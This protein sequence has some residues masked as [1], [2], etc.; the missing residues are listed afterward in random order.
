MAFEKA[1][2]N[3]VYGRDSRERGLQ[4]TRERTWPDAKEIMVYNV[5]GVSCVDIERAEM[6]PMRRNY[7]CEN[8]QYML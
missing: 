7:I 8:S 3:N 2:A 4:I 1:E 5:K 6:K